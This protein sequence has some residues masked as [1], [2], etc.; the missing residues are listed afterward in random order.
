MKALQVGAWDSGMSRSRHS[1]RRE[2][3]MSIWAKVLR[4]AMLMPMCR[5][6]CESWRR[7]VPE[8]IDVARQRRSAMDVQRHLGEPSRTLSSGDDIPAHA[9]LNEKQLIIGHSTPGSSRPNE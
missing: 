7:A 4:P 1:T 8:V 3:H 6:G 5:Q 9:H 2:E